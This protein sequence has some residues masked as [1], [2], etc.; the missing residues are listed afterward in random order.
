LSYPGRRQV[1]AA[2]GGAVAA[3]T[4]GLRPAAAQEAAFFRMASGPTESSMFQMATLI[5]QTVSSP[6]GARECARGGSCGVPGLIV[7]NQTTAGSL[8]NID[9]VASG[10]IDSALCQADL[11]YWAHHGTGPGAARRPAASS[12]RAIANLYPE[13]LHLVTRRAAAIADIRGLRGK[14]VAFGEAESGT[15]IA[16]RAVL[17]AAGLGE[18]DVRAQFVPAAEAVEAMVAGRLDALFLTAGVPSQLVA[19]LAEQFEIS[20]L[21]LSAQAGRLR[22]TQPFLTE[23][24][25]PAGT[26]RGVPEILSLSIGIVWIV[27]AQVPDATVYGI[28]RALWHPNNRRTLDANAAFGRFLR[29]EAAIDGL[30][31]PLHPGAAAYYTETG[32]VR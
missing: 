3:L 20:I 18:R 12:L 4:G 1:L 9:L 2:M 23:A 17:Q 27:G 29:A 22:A 32:L 6:P 8:A 11:A 16:A 5:G 13:T 30:G 14:S 31:F 21:P 24:A 25:I 26:Y 28:T 7:V 15:A 10:R 19:D